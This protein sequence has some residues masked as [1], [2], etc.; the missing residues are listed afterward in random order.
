MWLI[1]FSFVFDSVCQLVTN[2]TGEFHEDETS[3]L[4]MKSIQ[5]IYSYWLFLLFLFCNCF[6]ICIPYFYFLHNYQNCT[7]YFWSWLNSDYLTIQYC[8][9]FSKYYCT[10]DSPPN[11][12]KVPFRNICLFYLFKIFIDL[13]IKLQLYWVETGGLCQ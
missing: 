10:V 8:W 1:H 5:L 12:T 3:L 4:Q 13:D 2:A 9:S 6:P 11:K 7:P